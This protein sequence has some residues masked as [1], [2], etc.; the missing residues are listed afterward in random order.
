M[1]HL[2]E[3]SGIEALE[4]VVGARIEAIAEAQDGSIV[5]RLKKG[6]KYFDMIAGENEHYLFVSRPYSQDTPAD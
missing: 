3:F 5:F 1:V 6:R 4:A 2:T